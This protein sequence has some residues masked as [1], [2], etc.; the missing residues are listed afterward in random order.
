MK[1]STNWTCLTMHNIRHVIVMHSVCFLAWCTS[2]LEEKEA[3]LSPLPP[4]S[5]HLVSWKQYPLRAQ[6]T[7]TNALSLCQQIWP[8][9]MCMCLCAA[10]PE[11]QL[12]ARAT[13]SDVRRRVVT[14]TLQCQAVERGEVHVHSACVHLQLLV[15]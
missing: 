7:H 1:V 15:S 6:S 14:L 12:V 4:T 8:Y 13:V 5:Q 11:E 3:S 2:I 10:Y 9:I